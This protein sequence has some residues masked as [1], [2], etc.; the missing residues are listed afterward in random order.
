MILSGRLLWRRNPSA[1]HETPYWRHVTEK[2]RTYFHK[3]EQDCAEF[4]GSARSRL[5]LNLLH[6]CFVNLIDV[7]SSTPPLG[8]RQGP[9]SEGDRSMLELEQSGFDV[10]AFLTHA[11]LGR[12]IIQFAPRDAF[13]SQGDPA[14]AVFYL[15]KGR[16]KLT[17][18]S[19]GREGSYHLASLCRRLCGRRGARGNCWVAFGRC[20]C[21]YRR[22]CS[23]N[24]SGGDDPCTACGA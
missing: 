21:D 20:L 2:A 7:R 4:P 10:T 23:Q 18:V 16:A 22:H 13:F 11:G 19:P 5:V 1:L 6:S 3:G 8:I 15:Q 12:R 24:R 17:V 9:Q 14:D